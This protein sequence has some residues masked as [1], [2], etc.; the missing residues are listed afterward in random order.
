MPE[1]VAKLVQAA[2]VE[3]VPDRVVLVQVGNVADFGDR[4]PPPSGSRGGASDLQGAEQAGEI[5]QPRIAQPLIVEHQHGMGIDRPPQGFDGG[6]ADLPAQVNTRDPGR[7]LLLEGGDGK[8]HDRFL[9]FYGTRDH[10]ILA[11]HPSGWRDGG[12]H[13]VSPWPVTQEECCL[14]RA[15]RSFP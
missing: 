4:Q 5:P 11:C 1:P 13:G 7:E 6:G 3:H 14:A 15:R 2:A 12:D 8:G 9:R 10:A